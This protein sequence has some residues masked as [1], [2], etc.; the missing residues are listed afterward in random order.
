MTASG[1]AIGNTFNVIAESTTLDVPL[2]RAAT[3]TFLSFLAAGTQELTITETDSTGTNSEQA[4][5]PSQG[6]LKMPGVG[7]TWSAGPDASGGSLN[8][9]DLSTDATNDLLAVTIHAA[10]LSDGYDSVQCTAATGTCYAILTDL[11][12]QRTPTNLTSNLT[13]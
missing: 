3:V 6:A 4:L 11:L 7:G 5:A 12:V 2:T 10:E 9:F 13:A 1:V 8:V